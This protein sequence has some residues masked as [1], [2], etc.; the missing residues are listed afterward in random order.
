MEGW[1]RGKV[2]VQ[3]SEDVQT[4]RQIARSISTPLAPTASQR[5]TEQSI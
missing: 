3:A 5:S 4:T 1:T 2:E